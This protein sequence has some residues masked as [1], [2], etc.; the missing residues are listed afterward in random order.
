MA[1]LLQPP[2]PEVKAALVKQGVGFLE[3][4]HVEYA[5]SSESRGME[6]QR[7]IVTGWRWSLDLLYG[8]RVGE[9]IADAAAQAANL[10]I[11]PASG[12]DKNGAWFGFDSRA[13]NHI[14]KLHE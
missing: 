2:M 13:H 5:R 11:P 7:G 12:V 10:T 1:K 6:Y 3:A 4:F 14:G 8:E 9:E